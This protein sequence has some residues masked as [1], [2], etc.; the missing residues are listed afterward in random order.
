MTAAARHAIRA[1]THVHQAPD[2]VTLER[3]PAEFQTIGSR[4]AGHFFNRD[5][6]VVVNLLLDDMVRQI[7]PALLVLLDAVV[8][9][10]LIACAN[11]ANLFACQSGRTA[12]GDRDP[13]VA[14]SRT[15]PHRDADADR[16][17]TAVGSRR[18]GGVAAG[19]RGIPWTAVEP[20]TAP[21]ANYFAVTP[22]YF[23]TICM[24]ILRGRAITDPAAFFT[25]V[26]GVLRGSALFLAA[27]G[28]YGVMSY[29]VAQRT[30]EI[31]I[32]MALGAQKAQVLM[33]VQRQGLALVLVGLGIG[34]AGALVLTQLMSTLLFRVQATDPITFVLVAAVLIAV[35]LA[36]CLIP[37]RRA[38][39]VDP[40][41]AL[42]YE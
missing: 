26:T 36:A 3:A 25:G 4:L 22:G 16:E 38:A 28:L 33:L 29:S 20:S 13:G 10:L 24:R 6:G 12:A 15:H 42:R 31:G 18:R 7:R 5:A 2:E 30:G 34:L 39:K 40:I 8:F 14:R 32:R 21:L 35:S 17:R 23:E 9:V 1:F 11:V 19:V 37:A 27:L 41:V